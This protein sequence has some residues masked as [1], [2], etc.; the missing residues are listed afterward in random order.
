[1]VHHQVQTE[2]CEN[3]FNQAVRAVNITD[4]GEDQS[5][6]KDIVEWSPQRVRVNGWTNE[7]SQ[8]GREGAMLVDDEG[9]DISHG[10]NSSQESSHFG[11]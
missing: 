9:K 8:E 1:V 2:P 4:E 3:Y 6:L 11:P 7:M 10:E 5:A